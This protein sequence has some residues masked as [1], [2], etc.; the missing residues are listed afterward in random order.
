MKARFVL[1]YFD[2]ESPNIYKK[3]GIGRRSWDRLLPGDILKPKKEIWIGPRTNFTSSGTGSKI[4]EESYVVVIDSEE[5]PMGKLKV[6]Y[7]QTWDL[8][9]AEIVRDNI[10]IYARGNSMTGS[11]KQF[12]NRFDIL[13]QENLTKG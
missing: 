6:W 11:I 5:T 12:E 8:D 1:E 10:E 2:R 7:Y 3:I 4:W 13:Q 9:Q